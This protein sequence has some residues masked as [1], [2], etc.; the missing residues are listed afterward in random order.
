MD[1]LNQMFSVLS[2]W[3]GVNIFQLLNFDIQYFIEHN[4][5]DNVFVGT[6]LT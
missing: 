1:L 6:N 2:S 4:R 5:L 3:K